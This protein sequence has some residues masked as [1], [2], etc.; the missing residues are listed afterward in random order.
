M[1]YSPKATR[2]AILETF[3]EFSRGQGASIV[4][5][6]HKGQWALA[7]VGDKWQAWL[8]IGPAWHRWWADGSSASGYSPD[9]TGGLGD[10]IGTDAQLKLYQFRVNQC[11]ESILKLIRIS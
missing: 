5:T 11:P 2:T 6:Y 3:T 4:E 10:V 8:R 7:L 9:C 1:R